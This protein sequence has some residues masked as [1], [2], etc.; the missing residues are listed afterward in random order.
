M[1]VAVISLTR[2]GL[3]RPEPKYI[4]V[5]DKFIEFEAFRGF[6]GGKPKKALN[7]IGKQNDEYIY[8]DPHYVQEA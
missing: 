7:F 6:I 8:L 4:G 2:I 3:D 5:L 1:S